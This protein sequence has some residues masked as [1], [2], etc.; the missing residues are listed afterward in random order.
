MKTIPVFKGGFSC[1]LAS[2]PLLTLSKIRLLGV[3]LCL[4][5]LIHNKA[6]AQDDFACGTQLLDYCNCLGTGILV[7]D[8]APCNLNS[9]DQYTYAL[10][11]VDNA[12]VVGDEDDNIIENVQTGG[13]FSNVPTGDYVIYYISYPNASA[14]TVENLL[15]EGNSIN[16]LLSLAIL[17][18][19]GNWVSTNPAFT[20]IPS[21]LATVNSESCG[22]DSNTLC[23]TSTMQVEATRVCNNGINGTY[24]LYFYVSG[25]EAPYFV[26]GSFSGVLS[27]GEEQEIVLPETSTYFFQILDANGCRTNLVE[28]QAVPCST[29]AVDLLDFEGEATTVGNQLSW[30]TAS[31]EDHSHFT[32][33]HSTDGINFTTITTI[34]GVGNS[35]STTY[36]DFTHKNAPA[37]INYY[38][39]MVTD[40]NGESQMAAA[41]I[42]LHRGELE[43]SLVNL[44]PIPVQ[45]Y[46]NVDYIS[47]G[48]ETQIQLYTVEGRL[49]QAVSVASS[50]GLNQVQLPVADLPKGVY[51]IRMVE[52]GEA[53]TQK[54]IK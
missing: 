23:A 24:S 27:E 39:L 18:A 28:T 12:T 21:S 25:G 26:S 35:Y 47:T 37:G 5:L 48:T 36:Y 11:D 40:I 2:I 29:L 3:I 34:N 54:F 44:Y 16:D 45:D 43:T 20:V 1:L 38:R 10:V 41:V 32:L 4:C 42:T 31:E 15:A 22:C 49:I 53:I 52:N 46:L 7:A 30:T 13:L 33:E 14:S 9:A 19:Q 50:S 17:D 51:I 8:A 6:S